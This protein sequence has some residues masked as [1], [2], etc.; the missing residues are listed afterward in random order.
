MQKFETAGAAATE[1]L[2]RFFGTGYLA[3][4][5]TAGAPYA[6]TTRQYYSFSQASLENANT[7]FV[8]IKH[9]WTA[10]VSLR[11]RQ[12]MTYRSFNFR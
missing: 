3:F 4:G 6:G 10:S 7:Y 5:T 8:S 11:L 1:V 9:V 2:G 12:D